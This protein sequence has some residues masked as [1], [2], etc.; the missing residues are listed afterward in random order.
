[1]SSTKVTIRRGPA[2]GRPLLFFWNS[3]PR[4]VWLECFDRREGHTDVDL[5]YMHRCAPI[6][7]ASLEAQELGQCWE[8][9]GPDRVQVDIVKRLQRPGVSP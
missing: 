9:I 1:M 8:S 3:N 7:P 2:T 6:D 5:A 4:T